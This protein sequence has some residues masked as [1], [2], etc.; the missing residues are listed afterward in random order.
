MLLSMFRV[1]FYISL[2]LYLTI[3]GSI[4]LLMAHDEIAQ[5]IHA[6]TPMLSSTLIIGICFFVLTVWQEHKQESV[7]Q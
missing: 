5:A 1:L 3:I 7:T 2:T 4:F 6:A